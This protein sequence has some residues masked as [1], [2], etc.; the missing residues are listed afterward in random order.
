MSSSQRY[1]L[2]LRS[3][4]R[5]SLGTVGS[6]EGCWVNLRTKW[7]MSQA[8]PKIWG[9]NLSIASL[10]WSHYL[11]LSELDPSDECLPALSAVEDLVGADVVRVH[12][13]TVHE[14]PPAV[15]AHELLLR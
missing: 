15:R 6:K 14:A 3:V 10:A 12:L 7:K 11:V 2:V 13:A 9:H 5:T 8:I 4:V 1:I